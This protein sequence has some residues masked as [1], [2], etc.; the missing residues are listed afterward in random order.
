[1]RCQRIA[2]ILCRLY[3][4]ECNQVKQKSLPIE[5]W[6]GSSPFTFF[7]VFQDVPVSFPSSSDPIISPSLMLVPEPKK[8]RESLGF[9]GGSPFFVYFYWAF[10]QASGQ[11]ASIGSNSICQEILHGTR[12]GIA[13]NAQLAACPASA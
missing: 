13:A 5:V 11:T 4:T 9:D 3:T 12:G 10:T 1:M 2:A 6:F 7:T 8:V